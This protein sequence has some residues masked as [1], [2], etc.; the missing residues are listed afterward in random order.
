MPTER[1]KK[2]RGAYRID[3]APT[4]DRR[5]ELLR[6]P[7]VAAFVEAFNSIDDPRHRACIAWLILELAQQKKEED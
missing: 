3:T 6:D 2:G 1:G 4:G 7:Q 5:T